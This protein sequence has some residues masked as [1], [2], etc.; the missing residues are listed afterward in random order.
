MS[1]HLA[2]DLGASSGRAVAGWEENGK[3]VTEEIHRFSNDPV[4]VGGTV[5]WDVLRLFHEIKQSIIKAKK[6]P[7]L[8]SIGIDTWGVDFGLIGADGRLLENP[9]HYR[10]K[11]TRGMAKKC[12]EMISA[13]E[14]YKLTGIQIMDINTVYQ[15]R[16]LAEQRPQLLDRT[17]KILMMPDLLS[18]FL[19]DRVYTELSMA[20]TT[21]LLDAVT[22]QW[23]ADV[24]DKTELPGRVLPMV[25]MPGTVVGELRE[26]LCAE[27]GVKAL[28]VVAV[29]GHDTQCA[30]AAA[31]PGDGSDFAFLSMGT[32][33]LLGTQL[34]KPVLSDQSLLMSFTNEKGYKGKTSYLKNLTGLWL[35]QESRR[36]WN[37]NGREYSFDDMEK[38]AREA[39][40]RR[41]IIDTDDAS[42]QAPGDIPNRIALLCQM[43]GQ[44][45]P[46]EDGEII[47]C[48]YD[49]LA[50][51]FAKTLTELE[52]CTGKTF[53]KVIAVGGGTKDP[54]L[55]ELISEASG[56]Q[57]IKGEAE[58]SALGNLKIQID[59]FKEA[60]SD[61]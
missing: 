42:L 37:K 16:A 53:E 38:L 12:S 55:L 20:S 46:V 49:S 34:D 6:F 26:E 7:D 50:L 52:S 14:I 11:R 57:V 5:Y 45:K 41:F 51:K 58:A 31:D 10:D 40:P 4:T 35:L 28:K 48:I 27:L 22:N 18:Y 21:Q 8:E 15:L 30:M 25:I 19:S 54:L 29:C 33:C 60:K 32:W 43:R 24:I 47:R 1:V 23:S 39:E 17:A 9:V 56:R 61:A 36:Y 59:T 3:V 2:I 44:G 13:E